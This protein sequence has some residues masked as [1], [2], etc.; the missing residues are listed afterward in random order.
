MV[1]SRIER[2]DDMQ[3]CIYR[4]ARNLSDGWVR[5]IGIEGNG[6]RGGLPSSVMKCGV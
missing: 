5:T 6:I 1:K 4:C 2:G 3:V